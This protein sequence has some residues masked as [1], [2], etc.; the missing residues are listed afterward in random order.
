M[1]TDPAEITAVS[2]SIRDWNNRGCS[3]VTFGVAQPTGVAW[4]G[5]DQPPANT[6]WVVRTTE[7]YS[8]SG[9]LISVKNLSNQMVAALLYMHS[10][11]NLQ[12]SSMHH[13]IDNLAKHE[14]S[15]SFGIGNCTEDSIVQ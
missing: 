1:T 15:H 7:T 6:M 14:A 11:Y 2:N 12:T 9:Q 13:R 8:G 4:N 3:G 10:D 5:Q